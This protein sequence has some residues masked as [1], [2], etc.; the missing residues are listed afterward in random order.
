VSLIWEYSWHSYREN[1]YAAPIK[2]SPSLG[3]E[4]GNGVEVKLAGI[5]L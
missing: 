1:I 2:A 3:R 5:E 4:I